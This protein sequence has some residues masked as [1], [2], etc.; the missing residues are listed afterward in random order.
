[1]KQEYGKTAAIL[2]RLIDSRYGSDAAFERAAGL[3]PKTVS[4]WRR[5]I[6]ASYMKML[7]TLARLFSVRVEDLLFT[8]EKP[9]GRDEVLFLLSEV[10]KLPPRRR[11]ALYESLAQVIGLYMRDL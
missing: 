6:S 10:E 7:P 9:V 11:E 4:N 3:S 2:F 5:G 1:M 8:E